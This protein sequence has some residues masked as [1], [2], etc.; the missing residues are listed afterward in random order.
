MA[1]LTN[2][3]GRDPTL[4]AIDAE[5]ARLNNAQPSRA[6][7]GMSSAGKE[8]RRAVWFDFRWC[9]PKQFDAE[10][11]KR[12]EDGHMGEE[13]QA[14]RLRLVR[15]I[16]LFTVDPNS[17]EQF[18]FE[19]LGGHFRGH[20]DG[21]I[22]GLLQAPQTWHV[23]EH[24]Q[25]GE[26]TFERF[27]QAKQKHGEKD[28]LEN[29]N[30]TYFAQAQLYMAFSGMERHYLTV[31]TPGGRATTSA[32]TEYQ[33][34]VADRL[35]ERALQVIEAPRPL[36]RISE[37]PDWYVCK[38]CDHRA[39]CHGAKPAAVSC[40]TCVHATPEMDGRGSWSCARHQMTLS[41]DTQRTGC[42]DHLYIPEL[43]P[44]GEPVDANADENWIEYEH[45]GRRF[46]NG[47]PG[48]DCY[49]STELAVIDVG[50]LG[51]PNVAMLRE[52]MGGIIVRSVT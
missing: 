28:A 41:A 51:D 21:A 37:K 46:R 20:M 43:L 26:K 19:A 27:L 17:G 25:V 10:A 2:I 4:D 31:S 1:D 16:T 33:K 9:T 5:L 23:W 48:P 34:A 45:A 29:W 35:I 39:T 50:A 8:C 12:F 49:A 6:Y 11:V 18:G 14:K 15:N 44:F 36:E 32:R 40:R 47:K 38:F 3:I 7:L 22:V 42:A 24:K 30:A 13:M 52:Q